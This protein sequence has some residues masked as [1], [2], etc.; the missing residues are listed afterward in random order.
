DIAGNEKKVGRIVY[1]DTTPPIITLKWPP[2]NFTTK[3]DAIEVS[4]NTEPN[5]KVIINGIVI[6][7]DSNGEF[8]LVL[9]MKN[10]TNEVVVSAIDSVGNSYTLKRL[11]YKEKTKEEA[12][13]V[14]G[15]EVWLIIVIIAFCSFAIVFVALRRKKEIQYQYYYPQ[16]PTCGS[17]IQPGQSCAYCS[18]QKVAVDKAEVVQQETLC[19]TCGSLIQPGQSCAYCLQQETEVKPELPPEMPSEEVIEQ[20]VQVLKCKKCDGEIEKYWVICPYCG[21]KIE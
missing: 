21:E 20:E 10:E 11:V 19:P 12:K 15:L 16:C 18:M 8:R 2:E 14:V 4:G 17:L 9:Q 3:D 7:S 6:Y 13:K 5:T 1:L